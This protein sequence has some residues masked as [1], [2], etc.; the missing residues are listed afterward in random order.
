MG[1]SV[2][3]DLQDLLDLPSCE[4]QTTL[5]LTLADTS[6]IHVATDAVT[7]GAIDYSADLRKTNELRQTTVAPPDRVVASIQ[8]V[9]KVFGGRVTDEDL[10]KA[11]AVVGR[12]YSDPAGVLPSVWVQ[13]FT[14]E[15]FPLSVNS[16]AVELEILH[17]L[18][19]AGYCVGQDTLAENCQWRFKHAGTCGYSGGETVCNKKRKSKLG[20][21]GRANE[22]RFGGM[23]YPDI[24]AAAAPTSGSSSG[25]GHHNCPRV[26]MWIPTAEGVRHAGNI[27]SGDRLYSPLSGKFE[28]VRSAEIIENEPIW[29]IVAS[30]GVA[31]YSS[32]SHPVFPYA[33]HENGIQVSQLWQGDPILLWDS[34]LDKLIDRELNVARDTGELGDVVRIELED[35]HIYAYG[36]SEQ[37]FFV[38]HNAKDPAEIE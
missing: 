24:Q 20:C 6:E 23:E 28:T 19:A 36:T 33:E 27:K 18:V 29:E 31:G 16:L 22:H 37:I 32:L 12:R 2:S 15:A 26:D 30:N 17:D 10:I 14:G 9:D 4:T 21:L 1:R 3:S 11:A 8:N 7:V 35:G 38:C 34:V 25:G 5:D 13:L